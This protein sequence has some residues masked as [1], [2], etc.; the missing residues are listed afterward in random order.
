MRYNFNIL[1]QCVLLGFVLVGSIATAAVASP[2]KQQGVYVGIGT[3]MSRTTANITEAINYYDNIGS[4]FTDINQT[5]KSSNNQL[6]ADLSIGYAFLLPQHFA[7]HVAIFAQS[8][9]NL[10]FSIPANT[11]FINPPETHWISGGFTAKQQSLGYGLL[12][13][14][15]Y[16]IDAK[17]LLLLNF[18]VTNNSIDNQFASSETAVHTD[19]RDPLDASSKMKSILGYRVGLGFEHML[20]QQLSLVTGFNYQALQNYTIAR[21]ITGESAIGRNEEYTV[22]ISGFSANIGVQYYF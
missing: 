1:H 20:G 3:A 10:T 6:G 9:N 19:V 22:S 14:P 15:G 21:K 7:L 13:S 16:F 2:L 11:Q 8:Q 4:T 12:V 17:N 18:G 5:Q